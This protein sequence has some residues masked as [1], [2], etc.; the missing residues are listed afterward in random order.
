MAALSGTLLMVYQIC[1]AEHD[2]VLFS[3]G[4][5]IFFQTELLVFLDNAFPNQ[6]LVFCVAFCGIMV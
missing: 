3:R 1:A 6:F 5:I 4:D 2:I